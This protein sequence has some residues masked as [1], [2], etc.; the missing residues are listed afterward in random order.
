MLCVPVLEICEDE[1]CK[2]C[3][4]VTVGFAHAGASAINIFMVIEFLTYLDCYLVRACFREGNRE[5]SDSAAKRGK[6]HPKRSLLVCLLS[7]NIANN[8]K[9]FFF[10][11]ARPETVRHRM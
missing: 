3:Q 5:S 2:V 10:A 6:S 1:S 7:K 8:L 11:L 9:R 4:K